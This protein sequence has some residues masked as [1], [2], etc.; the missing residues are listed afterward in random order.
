MIFTPLTIKAMQL[1][2]EAH[3]GQ[4]DKCGVPYVFHPYRVA[5]A[6]KDEYAV[7]AAL[8]H[9]TVEDTWVTPEHLEQMGFPDEVVSAVRLLTHDKKV[10]Y[11]EYVRKI[12]QNSIAKAVKLADLHDNM[13]T[14]RLDKVDEAALK[15]LEKYREAEKL[16]LE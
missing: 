16:L 2:Y 13:N 3:H 8:L 7:C 10:P 1:S 6:Q 5:E 12:K 14:G 11:M 4:K 9:D 15:R